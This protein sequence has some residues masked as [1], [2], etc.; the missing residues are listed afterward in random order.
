[1]SN[2]YLKSFKNTAEYFKKSALGLQDNRT[3][4]QYKHWREVALQVGGRRCKVCGAMDRLV[5]HHIES[6]EQNEKLRTDIGNSAIFCEK[7]HKEYHKKYPNIS[8]VNRSTFE[9]YLK[10]NKEGE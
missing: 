3:D 8:D 9:E 10:L 6:Y 5:V 2:S 1:M 4:A 7:H